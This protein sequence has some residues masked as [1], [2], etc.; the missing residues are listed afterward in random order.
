[1]PTNDPRVLAGRAAIVTGVSRRNGIGFAVAGRLL[2]LGA[3][4]F[5]HSWTPHDAAQPQAP[6]RWGSMV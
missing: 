4:V 6:T 2:A 5:A 3:A 1:M